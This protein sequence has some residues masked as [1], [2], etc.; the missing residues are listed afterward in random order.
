[1]K[2]IVPV[3]LRLGCGL[4]ALIAASSAQAQG[5]P[6]TLARIIDEG[7]NRNQ[8]M[9]HLTHLTQKIGHRLTGS[10]NLQKACEWTASQFKKFGLS[11][12]KL[13]QWGTIPV[14]FH[15]GKTQV[16][17]M[18]KPYMA[19][20]QFTTPSWTPGTNGAVRG[21]A[22]L[23]PTTMEEYDK[24]KDRLKG[25]WLLSRKPMF[26]PRNQQQDDEPTS[27]DKLVEASGYAGKVF[28]SRNELV[29]TSGRMNDLDWHNLPKETRV[30]VRKSDFERVTYNL[31]RGMDVQLEFNLEQK[32]L[33]GP[34]PV[35]NVIADIPGTE[36]PEEIVIV[37][38]H[39]DS[40]DGPGAQGCCDNGTGTMVALET[41]RILMA[42]GAK[43]KRTIRFIMWTGEEQGL[44]GSRRYVEMHKD[45]LKNVSAVLV[46]DGGTNY[47]GG[48]TCVAPMEAMLKEAQAPMAGV[49]PNL[50]F[51]IRVAERMP[52]GGG[53]DHAPFNAVGVPGFFWFETGRSDYNYVHH[54]QHDHLAMAI[55]EYLVQ[56]ATNSAVMSY[57]LACA[58]TM[59]PRDPNPPA[60]TGR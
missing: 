1:M 8:V 18:V 59:L 46:D 23:E 52:R 27:V 9:S 28:S 47:Q 38:G 57:N 51:E 26:R 17:R 50:P 40:W 14:G 21:P 3:R 2:E 33:R 49:F 19:N 35:Y 42:S 32:F 7:K 20:F 5:D 22:V 56:S 48:M 34:V 60:A 31:G 24:V 15:R 58:A 55:P 45:D 29:I 25:A 30:L 53:S 10:P 36:K 44:Y 39:L 12:V 4:L 41:A 13:E 43:P 6:D 16:G 54:T 11:N 37:S